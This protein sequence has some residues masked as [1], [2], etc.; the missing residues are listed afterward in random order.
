[1]KLEEFV[2]I[3]KWVENEIKNITWDAGPADEHTWGTVYGMREVLEE[4]ER[5]VEK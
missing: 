2:K 4:I 3:K 5:M 1:M